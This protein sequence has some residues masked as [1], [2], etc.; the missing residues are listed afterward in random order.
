MTPRTTISMAALAIAAGLFATTAQAA[1]MFQIMGG[2]DAA[3]PG[4][5][6]NF[7]T[8]TSGVVRE[9]Q[10]G[11]PAA[12]HVTQ[13]AN[14]LIEYIG[15]EAIN[16]NTLFNWGALSGGTLI[17]NSGPGSPTTI[18]DTLNIWPNSLAN[19]AAPVTVGAAAGMLPFNFFVSVGAKVVPNGHAGPGNDDVAFFFA[20][21][22]GNPLPLG[23]TSSIAYLL[24]DD[25]G[26]GGSG[27]NDHDDMIM[28]LTLTDAPEPGTLAV[29]GATLAGLGFARRRRT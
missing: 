2:A 11:N 28:R 22:L 7:I 25:G 10:T 26:G 12:L 29:L 23:G 14:I 5:A 21:A 16:A 1:P 3:D 19:L 8:G 17:S 6:F 13:A 15:K 27:D 9:S 20:D 24:L 18:G 4:N